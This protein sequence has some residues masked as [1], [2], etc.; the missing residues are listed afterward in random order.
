MS[1]STVLSRTDV[2]PE[3][4]RFDRNGVHVR[5]VANV[6]IDWNDGAGPIQYGIWVHAVF[7]ADGYKI[8]AYAR[9]RVDRPSQY[10]M[11]FSY[12]LFRMSG[13][14]RNEAFEKYAAVHALLLGLIGSPGF[15][16]IRDVI[17][18]AETIVPTTTLS[19]RMTVLSDFIRSGW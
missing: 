3:S 12:D 18:A 1:V 2:L 7:R 6:S 5:R 14:D 4:P 15:D 17:D 16:L 13:W 8:R 19:R 11:S 9:T 10:D